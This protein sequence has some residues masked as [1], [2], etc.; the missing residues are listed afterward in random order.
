MKEREE[1]K[2]VTGERVTPASQVVGGSELSV[3]IPC[4]TCWEDAGTGAGRTEPALPGSG[5]SLFWAATLPPKPAPSHLPAFPAL[6]PAL[7]PLLMA[8]QVIFALRQHQSPALDVLCDARTY[9]G[10]G[11]KPDLTVQPAQKHPRAPTAQRIRHMLLSTMWPVSP[12]YLSVLSSAHSLPYT[13]SAWG[14][15]DPSLFKRNR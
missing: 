11:L 12:D 7:F 15:L 3:E 4:S 2:R 6:I 10:V 14:G 13:L 5:P 9:H 1:H 8:L